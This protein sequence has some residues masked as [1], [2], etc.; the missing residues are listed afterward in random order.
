MITQEL[1]DAVQAYATDHYT[2]GGWDVIVE[3]F[4]LQDLDDCLQCFPDGHEPTLDEV[5]VALKP[6]IEIWADRQADA[7]N[8]AF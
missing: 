1:Y 8:S 4:E 6:L 5:I 3:C 2:D 7:I